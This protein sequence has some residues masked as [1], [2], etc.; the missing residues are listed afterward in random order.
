MKTETISSHF[1]ETSK[2]LYVNPD[3]AYLK[4]TNPHFN[5]LHSY[6]FFVRHRDEQL[7]KIHLER[8]IESAFAEDFSGSGRYDLEFIT[9][10]D[11][12]TIFTN[13]SF[14][15]QGLS[16]TASRTISDRRIKNL[17]IERELKEKELA[18]KLTDFCANQSVGEKCM[19]TSPPGLKN[20]YPDQMSITYLGEIQESKTSGNGKKL[21]IE[22][23]I[24]KLTIPGH[25]ALLRN[26][27]IHLPKPFLEDT[28]FVGEIMFLASEHDIARI[29]DCINN[30][31]HFGYANPDAKPKQYV[32]DQ[33]MMGATEQ[34]REFCFFLEKV[35]R[36]TCSAKKLLLSQIDVD[37]LEQ[38]YDLGYRSVLRYFTS[39]QLVHADQMYRDFTKTQLLLD[40]FEMPEEEITQEDIWIAND[41]IRDL[42][43]RYGDLSPKKVGGGGC[44][45]G[46]LPGFSIKTRGVEYDFK[47][48]NNQEAI[49][50]ILKCVKCPFCKKTVD[51]IVTSTHIICPECKE[52]AKK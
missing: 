46:D 29:N 10:P 51:A 1:D 39:E 35:M 41:F 11:G 36:D 9:Q 16:E 28:D 33:I 24:H 5:M 40:Q 48:N 34:I 18:D 2:N 17:P 50:T 22:L 37:H 49:V 7:V 13:P 8:Q 47:S 27:D 31:Q 6:D 14:P 20:D 38:A 43:D 3:W 19:W 4:V 42:E 30:L 26:M 15:D 44:P 23:I 21:H 12:S 45:G 32:T 52:S 25:E